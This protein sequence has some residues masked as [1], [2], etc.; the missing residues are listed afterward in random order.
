MVIHEQ[1]EPKFELIDRWQREQDLQDN[2][3][4]WA[5]QPAAERGVCQGHQQ[6][7]LQEEFWL[8]ITAEVKGQVAQY[9]YQK[10]HQQLQETAIVCRTLPGL[11]QI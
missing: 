9:C 1:H 8:R 7:V 4:E 5:L 6:D 11:I 2:G 10:K 3:T